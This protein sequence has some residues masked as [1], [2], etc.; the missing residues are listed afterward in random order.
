MDLIKKLE[1][2]GT[3]IKDLRTPDELDYRLARALQ[4]G[5]TQKKNRFSRYVSLAAAFVL[6]ALMVYNLDTLAFWN[7]PMQG[8]EPFLTETLQ[9]LNE[10]EAGQSLGLAISLSD[11]KQLVLDKVLIDSNTMLAF[12][13]LISSQGVMD[14]SAYT[15][16]FSGLLNNYSMKSSVAY[17]D[18]G[19]VNQIYYIA[20]FQVPKWFEQSLTFRFGKYNEVEDVFTFKI[21]RTQAMGHTVKETLKTSWAFEDYSIHLNQI[22]SSPTQ[23]IVSGKVDN[24][25]SFF[26]DNLKGNRTQIENIELEL[27]VD[28]EIYTTIGSSMTTN[29]KGIQFTNTFDALPDEIESYE[30]RLKSHVEKRQANLEI[31]LDSVTVPIETFYKSHA[32]I[33]EDI[34][35][36]NGLTHINFISNPEIKVYG[37]TLEGSNGTLPFVKT[38]HHNTDGRRTLVFD[39]E[40]NLIRLRIRDLYIRVTP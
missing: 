33:I 17:F 8:Y 14:A 39:G 36:E 29:L 23:T 10:T 34:W 9:R 1:K 2:D 21:D 28:G 37:V 16:E 27:I 6:V 18:D 4:R 12:Y 5:K 25:W 11:D 19:D 31:G 38:I 40:Q 32:I 20:E 15:A 13:R 30:I 35:A 26:I 7:N 22:V 24:W 3:G